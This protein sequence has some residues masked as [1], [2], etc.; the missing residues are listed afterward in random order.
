MDFNLL[1]FRQLIKYSTSYFQYTDIF[2]DYLK[3]ISFHYGQ[4]KL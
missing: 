2:K 3:S 1:A 4:D